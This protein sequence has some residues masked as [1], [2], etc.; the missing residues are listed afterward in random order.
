V[1]TKSFIFL[2]RVGEKLERNIWEQGIDSWDAFLRSKK[3]KMIS[4][5][6]KHYYD[7]Q[8]MKVQSELYSFNSN[9]FLD[10]LPQS[11]TWRLYDFFKEDAVFLDF[12]I[13]G[14]GRYDDITV[15]GLFDG[16]ETKSMI[17]GV[18]LDYDVLRRELR[19]YELI[20]TFNG[21]TFDI[22]FIKKR[23]PSLLPDVPNF[24]LRVACSRVGLSG[25]LKEIEKKLGIR[26]SKIIEKMYGGDP[27]LL[28]KMFRATGDDYYLRLLVEYNEEDVFNLKKIA[29]YVCEKLKNRLIG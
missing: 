29:D 8:L 14:M 25:G 17:K 19:K 18:N 1:I 10:R 27:F 12:E 11:E 20:V 9:Y 26:R 5:M 15:I 6:R 21:S 3:V 16:L 24:D 7:R 28:W 2:D 23:Y 4:K 13:S 22:P